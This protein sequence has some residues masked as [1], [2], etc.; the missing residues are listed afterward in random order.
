[1][2]IKKN[3]GIHFPFPEILLHMHLDITKI[4]IEYQL[5][6]NI[7]NN[8]RHNVNVRTQYLVYG[9]VPT[10]HKV[11]KLRQSLSISHFFTILMQRKVKYKQEI[12]SFH[13][14]DNSLFLRKVNLKRFFNS[15]Q[16]SE[17]CVQTLI[18]PIL[19]FTE[20]ATESCNTGTIFS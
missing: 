2:D 16:C 11:L 17:G 6:A 12:H 8:G 15:K 7:I 5:G 13:I 9:Y 1:M 20:R 19:N 3:Y 18:Q 4:K 14:N 10:I